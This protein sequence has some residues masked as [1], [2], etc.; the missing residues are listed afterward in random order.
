MKAENRNAFAI[1]FAA[2]AAVALDESERLKREKERY[3]LQSKLL[4]FKT[5]TNKYKKETNMLFLLGPIRSEK[6][7]EIISRT[8]TQ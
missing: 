2:I 1:V 3:Y 7:K 6:K 8:R 5:E 4:H